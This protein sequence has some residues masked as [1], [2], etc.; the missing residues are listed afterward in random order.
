[1]IGEQSI[2]GTHVKY[3]MDKNGNPLYY[4]SNESADTSN[5]IKGSETT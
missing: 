1:M 4:F 3:F 2:D 5:C